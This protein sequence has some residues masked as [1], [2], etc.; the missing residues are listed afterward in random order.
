[1]DVTSRDYPERV[2]AG[3][4]GKLAGV[5][6]GRPVE[7]WSHEDIVARFGEITTF[8]SDQIGR[9]V[10]VPDDDISG[11]FT[12]IRSLADNGFDPDLVPAQIGETWLN[13]VIEQRAILW[14]GG[15]GYS[16]EHT[17]F[18]NLQ[19][20]IPAPESGS[21]ARNGRVTAEQI[22]AQIF[23]DSWGLIA[24]GDPE[25]A[26]DLA[27]RA[28]SVSHDGAAIHAAQVVA[29]M[30]AQAFVDSNPDTL[31]D[32]ATA[33][34]PAGSLI[35]SVIAQVREWCARDVDWLVTRRRIADAYP[36]RLYPGN[37]HVVPNH[38]VIM[39]GLL[40]GAGDLRR[41]LSIATTAGWD[42]DCNAGNVGCIL[43]T[44]TG[45]SVFDDAP[46]LRL[47]IN[48]RLYL[49][50]A[51]GGRAITDAVIETGA[52]VRT[53][54]ALKEVVPWVPK[55]GA[56]FHF[57]LPGATQGFTI[58]PESAAALSNVPSSDGCGGNRVLR[59]DIQAPGPVEVTTPTFLRPE[60]TV[61]LGYGMLAS[62][63][64]YAGQ[65]LRASAR[66]VGGNEGS[67]RFTVHSYDEDDALVTTR[68]PVETLHPEAFRELRWRCAPLTDGPVADVGLELD[69]PT[70]S[71]V[72]IGFVTWDG[73]PEVELRPSRGSGKMWRAAWVNGVDQLHGRWPTPWTLSQNRG[74]GLFIQGTREWTDYRAIASIQ[75]QIA[76]RFGIAARVQGMRRYYALVVCDDGRVRLIR[77]HDGSDRELGS[78][79]VPWTSHRPWDLEIQVDGSR[80][81]GWVDGVP[82]AEAVDDAPLEGGAVA[83]V[84][85][86]GTIS[87]DRVR[88]TP[89]AS[90]H[91]IDIE[92]A[93][94]A[95]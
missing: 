34:I 89:P 78:A 52:L 91:Q 94:N 68:G 6:F 27:R 61:D 60:E 72:E 81:S 31:L 4:L 82:V 43:A 63:T 66:L 16:T 22:G 15:R 76:T 90:A 50:T 14:W 48:D 11:T 56:R 57:D 41:S 73:A 70:G 84:V 79:E 77:A 55:D 47:P 25:R 69:A 44:A 85:T 36:A 93:N 40:H 20:G 12:F 3:I 51:D 83:I 37:V 28:A 67:A 17:A 59:I 30:V 49:P 7:G 38:A 35:A 2:Y 62:P 53:A 33:Q 64:L 21:I 39:L 24:P 26:A 19:S 75:T 9:P 54:R 42:T 87:V 80:I 29:A 18:L 45:L 46:D 74:T 13:Y 1:M 5:Y 86:E 23:I 71:A 92:A 65:M 8:V 32:I 10:V 88:I 95:R 58:A